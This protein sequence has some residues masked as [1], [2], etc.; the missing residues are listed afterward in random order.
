MSHFPLCHGLPACRWVLGMSGALKASLAA[1]LQ[2]LWVNWTSFPKA[3]FLWSLISEL[4]YLSKCYSFLGTA[5]W[6]ATQT[7]RNYCQGASLADTGTFSTCMEMQERTSR[8]S[9]MLRNS[10]CS[11]SEKCFFCLLCKPW[12][13]NT[14]MKRFTR[15]RVERCCAWDQNLHLLCPSFALHL[16][17]HWCYF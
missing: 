8:C 11:L 6:V 13:W 16:F 4:S 5:T 14:Q 10:P 3:A 9:R 17:T 2:Q 1:L 7:L 12:K 15:D